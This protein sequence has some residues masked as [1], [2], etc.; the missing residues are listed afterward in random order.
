MKDW[1]FL[2]KE[3]NQAIDKATLAKINNMKYGEKK[4]TWEVS[5]KVT[6]G[7]ETILPVPPANGS[8]FT[9]SEL[10]EISDMT[11]N[12]TSEQVDLVRL[13]DDDPNHLFEKTIKKHG[14]RRP[15]EEFDK[16]WSIVKPVIMNLKWKFNRPRPYQL[17][18]M[19]R[20]KINVI[21]TETH[22]TPSYP[23]GHTAYAAVM[24]YILAEMYPE[25][26]SE[27]FSKVDLA[28]T[29]RVLQGVHFPFDNDAS[30]V[31]VGA[32]WQDIKHEII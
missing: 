18:D 9:R 7:W 12:V 32:L 29:A 3:A 21:E 20:I 1:G 14:L 28:G 19:Y 10:L 6:I 23:S 31:A 17:A 26:S 13:V 5:E 22:H 15:Q 24:C 30:M 8:V 16:A 27:I 2:I 4:K 11:Q 25:H